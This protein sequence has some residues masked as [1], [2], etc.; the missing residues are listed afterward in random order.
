MPV[1]KPELTVR[2]I[3][4]AVSPNKSEMSE[5]LQQAAPPAYGDHQE[6]DPLRSTQ[7]PSFTPSESHTAVHVITRRQKHSG[8]VIG[9]RFASL[10]PNAASTPF[11]WTGSTI[12]GTLSLDLPPNSPEKDRIKAITLDVCRVHG[13]S[14]V[15]PTVDDAQY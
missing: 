1:A 7:A 14:P 13:R 6:I 9:L 4:H 8:N 11:F 3:T 5:F 2:Q 15:N 12:S 10:A